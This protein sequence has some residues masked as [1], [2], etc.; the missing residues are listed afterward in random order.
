MY[1]VP[2]RAR[3]LVLTECLVDVPSSSRI[4]GIKMVHATRLCLLLPLRPVSTG[5]AA[6]VL[7]GTA[8][9]AAA[10]AARAI[11]SHTAQP[12]RV[13]PVYGTGPPPEPPQPSPEFAAEERA[14]REERLARRRRQAEMLK[15]AGEPKR[16]SF[17]TSN[18]RVD[19]KTKST[20]LKRR[21]WKEVHVREVNG[22]FEIHL[23]ARALRHPTTKSIIRLP[24]SKPHLAHALALEWD[25]LVSAQQATKQ[26]FIP[27]TS[28]T[29]RALDIATDPSIRDSIAQTLLRYLDTDSLLCF[30]PPPQIGD[31]DP[32]KHGLS[33]LERQEQ[34]YSETVAFLTTHVWPGVTIAPVLEGGSI[35]PR[36]H[37]AGTREVVQ[38]WILSSLTPFE[39]A[40]LERATLAG[41]SLL[42]AARLV[43]EWSE[44]GARAQHG[45]ADH[46]GK[47]GKQRFG[48]EAAARAVSLEVEYQT[49]RWGEVEDT[50]DV[51]REDLRRQLGSVV[52]LVSGTGKGPGSKSS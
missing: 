8:A 6:A 52:L 42:A 18:Q 44:D 2:W 10:T 43:V 46:H 29:C 47:D 20:G 23:D 1:P 28:L 19:G 41:K 22:M 49:G 11:H 34:A 17:K 26:H 31:H 25:S 13:V 50:H 4:G 21:F 48:V 36:K 45:R 39:V 14:E 40:G 38:G 27:L 15:L 7:R 37:E 9:A 16:E 30:S 3:R 33:L 24:L 51:E 5:A 12:A 32:A 35:M